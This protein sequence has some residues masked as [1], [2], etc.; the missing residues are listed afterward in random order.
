MNAYRR[1]FIANGFV[2][3]A[4]IAVCTFADAQNQ[5]QVP[6]R[7]QLPAVCQCGCN[8]APHLCNMDCSWLDG[9][10]DNDTH[11]LPQT[12]VRLVIPKDGFPP[13]GAWVTGAMITKV[14]KD[15]AATQGNT[16]AD[17]KGDRVVLQKNDI[18][19]HVDGDP[20]LTFKD[21]HELVMGAAG[22]TKLTVVVTE[23]GKRVAYYDYFTPQNGK[24]GVMVKMVKFKRL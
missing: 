6:V 13:K 9:H 14:Y 2:L 17:R 12:E 23:N 20:V 1:G 18:I 8:K 15:A 16:R 19:T 5:Q 10:D 7:K 11:E 24:L 3:F 21:L 22:Q 4:A